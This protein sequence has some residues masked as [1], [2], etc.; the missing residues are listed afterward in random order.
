MRS[1][2]KR[3]HGRAGADETEYSV[4]VRVQALY[5]RSADQHQLKYVEVSEHAG[6]QATTS[7]D[8]AGYGLFGIPADVHCVPKSHAASVDGRDVNLFGKFYFAYKLLEWLNLE[9]LGPFLHTPEDGSFELLK[10]ICREI[11][12]DSRA[13]TSAGFQMMLVKI[14]ADVD[15][16][17]FFHEVQE[18]QTVDKY[19]AIWCRVLWVG[20][21]AVAKPCTL[22]RHLTLTR[23]Q[24]TAAEEL[25]ETLEAAVGSD[26][27]S[28]A[29]AMPKAVAFSTHILRHR[30]GV[31]NRIDPD[32]GASVASAYIVPRA[33]NLLSL[34]PSGTFVSYQHITH[35]TAAIRYVLRSVMLYNTI[36]KLLDRAT[37][38]SDI[39]QFLSGNRSSAF[40]YCVQLHA[41][42]RSYGSHDQLPM[43]TWA[44]DD[45]TALR[46]TSGALLSLAALRQFLRELYDDAEALVPELCL[47]LDVPTYYARNLRDNYSNGEPGY[48]FLSEK[49]NH[50]PS[51]YLWTALHRDRALRGKYVVSDKIMVAAA[52]EYLKSSTKLL[53]TLFLLMHLTYGSPARMT[54]IDTW[55]HVNSVHGVRNVYCHPRGLVLLGLYNKTISM[56]GMKRF[57]VHLVPARLEKLFLTYL[58]YVRP[59]ERYEPN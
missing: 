27:E 36:H 10:P 29:R 30:Y 32:T 35:I 19:S 9:E 50:L 15:K 37:V 51:E 42:C 54:E 4:A 25:V 1:H 57:V 52:Q 31:T 40:A 6:P 17:S 21:L 38:D 11:L 55:K 26:D 23:Q 58:I 46:L 14:V 24:S 47:H 59:L 56:T 39:G 48:S 53:K 22:T 3:V 20:C 2:F 18:G 7:S 12:D 16:R 49:T 34:Q 45:F 8:A 5:G 13:T 43:I 28:Y 33:I 44:T 41:A